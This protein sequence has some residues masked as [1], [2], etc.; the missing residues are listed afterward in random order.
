MISKR[1]PIDASCKYT[2]V[3][4]MLL[5]WIGVR[6]Y[7]SGGAARVF[8][9]EGATI[10]KSLVA[11]GNVISALAER[12]TAGSGPGRRFIPYRDSSLTWLLKD[13]LGGNATTIMLASKCL[14]FDLPFFCSHFLCLSLSLTLYRYY[15]P[16]TKPFPPYVS[17]PLPSSLV[18][19]PFRVVPPCPYLFLVD[20]SSGCVST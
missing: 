8:L 20:A 5:E 1:K 12:G 13:A 14:P 2:D 17:P 15:P 10:N 18:P 3:E 9:Q 6:L 11:L 4:P 19:P 16:S 7:K